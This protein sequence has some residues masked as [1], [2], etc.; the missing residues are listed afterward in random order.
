MTRVHV[1]TINKLNDRRCGAGER[2]GDLIIAANEHADHFNDAKIG[3]DH[4]GGTDPH[5]QRRHR[6]TSH[7]HSSPSLLIQPSQWRHLIPVQAFYSEAVRCQFPTWYVVG[8]GAGSDRK[9]ATVAVV[10]MY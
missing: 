3:S 8:C 2:I 9:T 1:G 7:R 10:A 6:Q 5:W 4:R